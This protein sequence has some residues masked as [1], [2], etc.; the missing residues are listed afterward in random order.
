MAEMSRLVLHARVVCGAGGGPEKT[1]LNSPRF[2]MPFGY[3]ALCAYMRPP[4]DEGFE[5]IR[6]RAAETNAPLIEIDDRG[7]L[8][9]SVVRRLTELCCDRRVA[10]WHGHDYKSN[11]LGLWIRRRWPMKL[12]TTV[13]GWVKFTWK[14]PLYYAVDRLCLRHYQEVLCVSEDLVAR[15]VASGTPADRCT[16]IENA[17]DVEQYRR[18]KTPKEAKRELGLSPDRFL[19]GSVGRLSAEKNYHGLIAALAEPIRQG[20]PVDL[21]IVG[22]G[23]QRQK[24]E[25]L[26][27][28]EALEDRVHLLGYRA[29]TLDLYQAMDAYVL[30]SVREGLPN[31]LLEAMAMRVP[32]VATRVAGVPKLIEDEE[33]GLL[34]AP[35]DNIALREAMCRL[36]DDQ[37]LRHR[38]TEAARRTIERRYSFSTRMKKVRDVYDRLFSSEV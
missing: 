32:V 19:F 18:R 27:R 14:T 34:V 13:H 8:D 11:L 5:T 23:D 16:L 21:A 3:E 38:L 7:P 28:D 10:I 25:K 26:V 20:L 15:C 1:I 31:V 9:I 37:S 36:V 33:S 6:S 2:L 35:G 29:D 17:I 30:S 12:V 4:G 22:D 24:L